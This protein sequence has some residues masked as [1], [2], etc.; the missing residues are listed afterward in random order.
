MRTAENKR[1]TKI[2]IGVLTVVAL[3]LGLNYFTTPL[4][5]YFESTSAEVQTTPTVK[6]TPAANS[7]LE[8]LESLTPEEKVAQLIAYPAMIENESESES[9][10]ATISAAATDTASTD[11]GNEPDATGENFVITNLEQLTEFGPGLVVIFGSNLG[12][13]QVSLALDQL[14]VKTS[15]NSLL[16]LVAVDHE[17]GLVQR[18]SGEGFEK[19]PPW[20]SLCQ[21]DVAAIEEHLTQ[22]AQELQN[23]GINIV[24]APV[25]DLGGSV[26]GSR[27]CNDF[28]ASLEAAQSYIEIFG[29]HQIMSVIKH[30]P[31]IGNITR[32][33][34]F[35]LDE[36]RLD[37]EDT[38]IFA[39]V[40][41]Q[42][43]NIGV[44]TSHVMLEDKLE[45]LP[46]SL[47]AECLSAFPE[48]YPQALVFTDALNMGAIEEYLA[49][50]TDSTTALATDSASSI[51]QPQNMTDVAK[52]A[53]V[54]GNDI[55]VF[56]QEISPN[57]LSA[58]KQDL[59]QEYEQNEAFRTRVDI[60]LE[61]ILMIKSLQIN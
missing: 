59:A 44:M 54:A 27:S 24:F 40:L 1:N 39:R 25:L 31:G 3:L 2:F 11:D 43:P 23:V 12:Q 18:L 41:D 60:S 61:K 42:Y 32:D 49:L 33:L 58:I 38:Q 14:Q 56:G 4:L 47:S 34:H 28:D 19:L 48:N 15:S 37:S 9:V 36:I 53:I 7:K 10:Q 5:D 26:L 20:Q 55:L 35:G 29:K 21:E 13:Q 6:P 8:L 16:P 45:G 50:Q 52:Q 22:S 46:C 30:F 17:G 57:D 51:S